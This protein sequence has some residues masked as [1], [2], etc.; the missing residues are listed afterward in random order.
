MKHE[1]F[2]DKLDYPKKS[3]HTYRGLV[4]LDMCCFFTTNTKALHVSLAIYFLITFCRS[5]Q[6][7]LT[8]I[9]WSYNLVLRSY[10]NSFGGINKTG[11]YHKSFNIYIVFQFENLLVHQ[12]YF[13]IRI[14]ALS[15]R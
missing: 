13:L 12:K 7:A 15:V 11:D 8:S 9:I 3:K 1:L 5:R 10:H 14:T 4:V 2:W 6:L